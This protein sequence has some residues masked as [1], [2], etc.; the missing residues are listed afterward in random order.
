MCNKATDLPEYVHKGTQTD[1][2]MNITPFRIEQIQDDDKLVNFYTGFSTFLELLTCYHFLGASVAVLSCNRSKVIKD[3][4]TLCG[5][6]RSHILSPINE[7][8]MTLCRLRQGFPEQDLAVRLQISQPSVSRI[9]DTWINLFVKFKEVPI[10]PC[11]ELVDKYMP[12]CFRTM[13]PKTRCIIDAMEI[14]NKTNCPAVSSYKNHNT[15]KALIGIT[16]SGVI[17][18]IL[19]L[20]SGSISYKNIVVKS[21]F[22][23]LLEPGDSIMAD[24]GFSLDDILPPGVQLNIPPMMNETGQLTEQE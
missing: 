8:F 17:S 1:P 10:W 24:R 13:Y 15:L 19:D 22:L 11:W 21:G 7:F 9:L 14:F 23:K 20:Y 2:I 12:A 4:A 5:K 6:G 3:A 18:F 16:P